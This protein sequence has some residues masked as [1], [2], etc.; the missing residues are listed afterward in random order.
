MNK[1]RF[2]T[3]LISVNKELDRRDFL[4]VGIASGIALIVTGLVDR[5]EK[6]EAQAGGG[7]YSGPYYFG[8]DGNTVYYDGYNMP[9]NFY[10]GRTG[11]GE[12]FDSLVFNTDAAIAAGYYYTHSYWLLYGPNNTYRGSRTYYQWGKDQ[13]IKAASAWYDHPLSSY[14]YGKTFFADIE[15]ISGG[16]DGWDDSNRTNNREVLRGWLDGVATYTRNGY[17]PGFVPGIYTRPDLWTTWFGTDYTTTRSA[18]L[19][20]AGCN[21]CSSIC[22]PCSSSCLTTKQDADNRFDTV[23]ETIFGKNKTVIWQYWVDGCDSGCQEDFLIS[24]QSGNS[25]FSPIRVTTIYQTS[26]C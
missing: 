19:W 1:I 17:N 24:V 20:L 15:R 3:P 11:Y 18:T 4:K 10:I 25:Q 5:E 12:V 8:T 9:Q 21:A 6:L 22:S 2:R 14:F 23:K 26:G 7:S 13:G 16:W